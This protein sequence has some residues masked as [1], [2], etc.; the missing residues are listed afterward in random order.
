M[1]KLI[2]CFVHVNESVDF[3]STVNQLQNTGI[4]KKIFLMSNVK[5]YAIPE[6]CEWIEC[7]NF[8][9]SEAIK[10]IG[11]A[12]NTP[13]TLISTK[14]SPLELGAY[15]LE[16][17][18]NV[19]NDT[20]AGLVYSDYYEKKD[21]NLSAHPVIDYQAGSLRD[22]FNFGSLLFYKTDALKNGISKFSQHFNFAAF[23]DLR[24]KVSQTYSL[25]RIPEFLYSE[26]ELDTRKSGEKQFDY[27][28]PKNREV[29][30]EME[31]A[32]T[33]HLK[34]IDGYLKPDFEKIQFAADEFDFEASVV[35]PVRN[36]ARTIEDAIKSI[37][38]QKTKF[39]FNLIIV[40]NHS[41]DGTTEIIAKYAAQSNFIVH[42]I[43]ERKDLGIGGCW[44]AAVMDSRCGRFAVQLD[45]DDLFIDE[46]TLQKVVDAFYEQQCAMV[47]GTYKI[48]DVNLQMIPP[49]IIDHKEWTPDNGRNNA[50][51]I[52]GLGAPRAFYTPV[53][54]KIK[55]PNVSYG[56]DYAVGLAVS[57]NYQI[58]RIYEPLYLC[59]RWDGNS[60]AA[61]DIAKQNTYNTYK[62]RVR[63]IE[64][65][66]RIAKNKK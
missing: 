23:Y 41:T 37:L 58:G 4:V 25:F 47:V 56:E 66:A 3:L 17:F 48:V 54:R 8:Y 2:S 31:K 7:E 64:L 24:L 32:C 16:R 38:T 33:Q 52:N 36:R 59:R 18:V 28:D 30:I 62:D 6:N 19:M 46:N 63:S 29:Q 57:R 21:G 34:E 15:A 50:L 5:P 65:A 51:R 42:I 40:D 53:L 45:S 60:D 11:D 9:S 10:L 55:V 44:T 39:K 14:T 61:L 43:P 35:I 22:D 20:N 27:V 13:Y 1:E 26:V 12:A 49:G